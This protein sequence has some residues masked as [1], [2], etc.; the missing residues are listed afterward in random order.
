MNICKNPLTIGV[1]L[2]MICLMIHQ[3]MPYDEGTKT[4]AFT[5]KTNVRFLYYNEDII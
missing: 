1:V 4:Y 2:G 5:L 3:F